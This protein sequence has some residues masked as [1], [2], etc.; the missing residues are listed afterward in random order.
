MPLYFN[1]SLVIPPA[2]RPMGADLLADLLDN[3]EI[4]AGFVP[5][6]ILEDV[7]DSPEMLQKLKKFKY[8]IYGGGTS[9]HSW[10][11]SSS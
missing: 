7:C 9:L 10:F 4:E 1:F 2:G 8:I 5:P 11:S 3:V 6:S